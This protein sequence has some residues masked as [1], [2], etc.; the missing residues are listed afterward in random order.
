M[1]CRPADGRGAPARAVRRR[2]RR[3]STASRPSTPTS[4]VSELNR[5]AGRGAECGL[6]R[7]R[8]SHRGLRRATRGHPRE[9]RPD[10]RPARGALEGGGRGEPLP[11][12]R[13]SPRAR[14]LSVRA[15]CASTG[16]PHGRAARARR[17]PRLRR[18]R[19]GL[20]AR[21][22]LPS[23][24]APRES[25]ARCSRS[26]RAASPRSG[27]RPA[28]TAGACALTDTTGGFARD[29]G[30]PRSL[31]LGVG[32]PGPVGQIEGRRYGHVL[33]PRSGEPLESAR[34]AAWWRA[35][36]ATAEALSKG[37]LDA[38][39]AG[40]HR[41]RRAHRAREGWLDA[42]EERRRPSETRAGAEADALLAG[43]AEATTR[44]R[45]PRS[46]RS[47]RLR[48]LRAGR[49]LARRRAGLCGPTFAT[50]ISSKCRAH[51]LAEQADR[52]QGRES[53]SRASGRRRPPLRCIDCAHRARGPSRSS[54]TPS[55]GRRRPCSQSLTSRSAHR[56]FRRAS[57]S[58]AARSRRRSPRAR[59]ARARRARHHG[60]RDT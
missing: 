9:L 28:G 5:A 23:A 3:W 48:G 6:S 38:G 33:D 30:A 18:H 32:Q 56:E 49:D 10:G 43:L 45:A 41:A 40:G 13:S 54:R 27:P 51:A 4:E 2:S 19:E 35:E 50:N 37:L 17:G 42:E 57:R 58:A 31:A 47:P 24:C 36:G 29:R 34:V 8:A 44:A 1:R 21:P 55:P 53:R 12:P 7:A 46:P 15:A 26:A 52:A 59:R 20:G 11:A 22:L 16:E 60:R 25:L 14:T 39:R